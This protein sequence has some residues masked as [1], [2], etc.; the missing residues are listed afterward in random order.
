[1]GQHKGGIQA[2]SVD[3][4]VNPEALNTCENLSLI[5]LGILFERRTLVFGD[6]SNSTIDLSSTALLVDDCGNTY[7]SGWGGSPNTEGNTNGLTVTPNA[8]RTSTDGRDFYFLVLD[9]RKKP[10][11]QPITGLLAENMWMAEPLD[12]IKKAGFFKGSAQDAAE[13][14]R[15]RLIPQ[16]FI[17]P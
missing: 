6:S 4:W 10:G 13:I 17:H 14:V 9:P 5:A 7:F 12:L 3:F 15:T 16:M 1:M 2:S 8:V 11:W